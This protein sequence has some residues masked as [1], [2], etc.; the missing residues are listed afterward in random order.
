MAGGRR[1]AGHLTKKIQYVISASADRS[2]G[3]KMKILVL[4]TLVILLLLCMMGCENKTE[5][6]AEEKQ[7]LEYLIKITNNFSKE[8]EIIRNRFAIRRSII[9][10]TSEI[11]RIK[12][13]MYELEK[14]CPDF[15][16]TFGYKSAPKELQPLVKQLGESLEH[17]KVVAKG[18]VA[19]YSQD[20]DVAKSFQE[21]KE[22]LFYY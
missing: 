5:K 13:K 8:L 6:Y 1:P 4:S 12:P 3:I 11:K 10:F 9:D 14:I 15:K 21:L 18:K 16:K 19:K 7:T 17:M 20:K 22:T 2:V